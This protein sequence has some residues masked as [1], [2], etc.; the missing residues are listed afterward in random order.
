MRALALWYG[1]FMIA[2]AGLALCCCLNIKKSDG[3]SGVRLTR[4]G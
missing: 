2:P 3:G 4:R 1:G